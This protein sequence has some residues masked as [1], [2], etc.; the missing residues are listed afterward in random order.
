MERIVLNET[1][2][3]GG[4]VLDDPDEYIQIKASDLAKG[5][6]TF[7]VSALNPNDLDRHVDLAALDKYQEF[8]EQ[9]PGEF[10]PVFTTS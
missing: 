5:H 1:V 8:S 3:L 9:Y 6:V 7:F 4:V 2:M 10:K